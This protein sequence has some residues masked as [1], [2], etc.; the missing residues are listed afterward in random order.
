MTPA[1]RRV[2]EAAVQFVT[3]YGYPGYDSDGDLLAAVDELVK[4]RPAADE[5]LT[6]DP[7]NY[8][9]TRIDVGSDYMCPSCWAAWRAGYDHPSR[10]SEAEASCALDGETY[11]IEGA[12][13]GDAQPAK[14]EGQPCP[15][16]VHQ[17]CDD[18]D[19]T[20]PC[21]LSLVEPQACWRG[22]S[23]E[24]VH[25]ANVL[26]LAVAAALNAVADVIAEDGP[27][28]NDL[29]QGFLD[30]GDFLRFVARANIRRDAHIDALSDLVDATGRLTPQ[31]AEDAHPYRPGPFDC[32]HH[33][34]GMNCGLPE[35]DAVHHP[36][37]AEDAQPHRC[38]W[39]GCTCEPLANSQARSQAETAACCEAPTY[40]RLVGD[41]QVCYRCGHVAGGATEESKP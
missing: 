17:W 26:T 41:G 20:C 24:E 28:Q 23:E 9:G 30:A 10:R 25:F 21:Y 11:V 18:C 14:P 19:D 3:R 31:R 4:L 12:P 34:G 22:P 1:E 16:A 38:T 27:A 7:C 37:R 8:C 6:R 40:V 39:D 13:T 33:D 5:D 29:S 35:D 2:V 36:Q 32:A 15:C